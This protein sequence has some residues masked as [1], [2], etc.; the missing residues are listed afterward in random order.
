MGKVYSIII[1]TVNWELATK[2]VQAIVDNTS[3]EDLSNTEVVL[4]DNSTHGIEIESLQVSL[5]VIRTEPW[6]GYTRATNI[7]ITASSGEYVILMN[8]DCHILPYKEKSYWLE[9]LRK[10]LE[11]GSDMTGIKSLY[12]K[13][14]DLDFIV[15][16]LAM[17]RREIFTRVG[18]L[19]E[20]FNPG[21]GED[22]DF[23]G[24]LVKAGGKLTVVPEGSDPGAYETEYPA[25]HDGEKTVHQLPMWESGFQERMAN[26]SERAKRFQYSKYADV[27]AYI[28]TKGRYETTLTMAIASITSQ[29]LLPSHFVLIQDAPGEF[30]LRASNTYMHIFKLLDA[31]GIKWKVLF[32]KERGQVYNHQMMVDNCETSW[33]WRVDDD[34]VAEPNVLERLCSH[35]SDEVGAIAGA[36][37]DPAHVVN[38]PTSAKIAHIDSAAN[39]QWVKSTGV[40]EAEHL[41]SSFIY[42]KKASDHG[43]CTQLSVVGHREETIFSHEMHRAGWKLL[44]DP[45]VVTWHLRSSSGGIRTYA[46]IKLWNHD[47]EIFERKKAEWTSDVKRKYVNMDSGMGDH[48]I[49]KPVLIEMLEKYSDHEVVVISAHPFVFSDIKHDNLKVISVA[50]GYETIGEQKMTSLNVYAYCTRNDWN[51]PIVEAMKEIYL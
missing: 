3:D 47:E 7:G 11:S 33:L 19:D 36:V 30:D 23:C 8:D 12:S 35:I 16:F 46:D 40:V 29:T 1:P 24:R 21:G 44:I 14:I 34:N 22:I 50:E 39:V 25:W 2:C 43:Y 28:S 20:S 15:F 10:P 38:Y 32:G 9:E 48:W 31:K 17:M 42:R 5:N 41:Y 37:I 27:T 4:V 13:E 6:I 45:S 18:M 51:S 49:F 26:L